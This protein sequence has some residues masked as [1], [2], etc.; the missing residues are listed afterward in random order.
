[1][2]IDDV[3]W[4][5]IGNSHCSFKQKTETQTFCKNEYNLTGLCSRQSCPLA[6]QRYATILEKQGVDR[7]ANL[8]G[9]ILMWRDLGFELD[10]S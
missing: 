10:P 4:K 9:G 6:N 1:M 5:I 2:I 3:I 8:R 7:V